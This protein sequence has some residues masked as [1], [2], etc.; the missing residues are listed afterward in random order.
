MRKIFL[1]MLFLLCTAGSALAQ[2]TPD[3]PEMWAVNGLPKKKTFIVYTG[4]G[5]EYFVAAEGRAKVSTN[6]SILCY[7]RVDDWLMVYYN[8]S[9]GSRVGYID[10]GE[11][12]QVVDGFREL[13][14]GSERYRLPYGIAITDDPNTGEKSLGTVSGEVTLLANVTFAGRQDWVYVEGVLDNRDGAQVRGFVRRS[15]FAKAKPLIN[16]PDVPGADLALTLLEEMPVR[17]EIIPTALRILPLADGTLALVCCDAKSTMLSLHTGT[18]ER[19]W[20]QRIFSSSEYISLEPAEGGFKVSFYHNYQLMSYTYLLGS[21]DGVFSDDFVFVENLREADRQS[22]AA[23]RMPVPVVRAAVVGE[24]AQG[25][26]LLSAFDD[27]C[28]LYLLTQDALLL[29]KHFAGEAELCS[30]ADENGVFS[31]VLWG[32]DEPVLRTYRWE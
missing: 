30:P 5:E 1:M 27:G 4:P 25:T 9:S 10:A 19:L 23:R 2:S 22:A 16:M 13:S 24:T 12:A 31:L 28:G 11:Y 14:F 26:L 21:Q 17:T 32:E 7:G 8:T 29:V 20:N 15:S 18:G 6:G 3:L